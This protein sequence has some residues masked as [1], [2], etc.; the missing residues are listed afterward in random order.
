MVVF[1]PLVFFPN[2]SATTFQHPQIIAPCILYSCSQWESQEGVC[3]FQNQSSKP[4]LL[5]GTEHQYG[6]FQHSCWSAPTGDHQA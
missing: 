2:L 6:C 5:T 4:R 3:L 1:Q